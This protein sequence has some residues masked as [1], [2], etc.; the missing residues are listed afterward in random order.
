MKYG[1]PETKL[2]K[3]LIRRAESLLMIKEYEKAVLSYKDSL[4]NLNHNNINGASWKDRIDKGLGMCK[5]REIYKDL[6]PCINISLNTPTTLR[7]F[8]AHDEILSMS[9]HIYLKISKEDGRGIFANTDIS[10]GTNVEF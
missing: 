4:V 9:D 7:N 2:Y 3:I 8:K 6:S 10:V 1:Y 5:R